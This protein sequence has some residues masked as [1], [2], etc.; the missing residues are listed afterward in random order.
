MTG[1]YEVYAAQVAI[2]QAYLDCT[3]PALFTVLN[4]DT[5]E[6]LNF[7][8]PFDPSWRKPPVTAPLR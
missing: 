5:C 7:L 2:Y 3:N 6:R 4:A 8:V 1:L